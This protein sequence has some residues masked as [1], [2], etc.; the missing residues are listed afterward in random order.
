MMKS[1]TL[2]ECWTPLPLYVHLMS[3]V[4]H[5]VSVSRPFPSFATLPL[6]CIT[7]STNQNREPGNET[8]RSLSG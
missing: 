1:D 6:P 2:F 3:D 7:L 5:V 8:T 4:I